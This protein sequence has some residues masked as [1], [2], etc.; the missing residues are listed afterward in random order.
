MSFAPEPAS[1]H[2]TAATTAVVLC[3][4][5][6]PD[7]PTPA[8]VR[9]Y[10]AR[11]PRATRAWSRF[12]A[13]SGGRSCTAS[14][15]AS[16]RRS[17]RASTPASGRPEGSPLKVWTEKQALLLAGYLG[18]RGHRSSSATR[19]ATAQPSIAGVLDALGPSRRRPGAGAAALSA[20]RRGDDGERRRRGRRLDAAR[21]QPAR[22]C[23][24]SSTTTTTRATSARWRARVNEHW[25]STAAPDRLVLSFHGLPRRS[26][27][28]GDPYHCECLKTGAPPRR[29][30]EGARGYRGR[31]LP[32]PLRQGRVA[33]ALHRAD[34]GR[35]GA[36]GR[37]PGRRLLPRLHADCLETLEEIDQ[38]ARAAFLAAGGKEFGYV[39]LPQR[40]ARVDRRAGRHCDPPPAGLG[41]RADGDSPT[42]LEPQRRRALSR[43]APPS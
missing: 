40:P 1:R 33:A 30:A 35:P 27:T 43:P 25:R 6:T 37:R 8:A 34:A 20:V 13:C 4:L 9:R 17:R 28:L 38:E 10:L 24:S 26:L 32:E 3:N 42:S 39:A 23:A 7:A 5:G 41:H 21:P 14:S 19:C 2:G 31:H 18:Q 15:C 22:S 36:R 29:A 12:R 11:V 16:G